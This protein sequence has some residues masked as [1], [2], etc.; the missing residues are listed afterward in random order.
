MRAIDLFD[1]I[2]HSNRSLTLIALQLLK[3]I[4]SLCLFAMYFV[5]FEL[6]TSNYIFM[7]QYD[8]YNDQVDVVF[9]H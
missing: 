9:R 7:K 6:T 3:R 2:D 1:R 5:N 4:F 8:N